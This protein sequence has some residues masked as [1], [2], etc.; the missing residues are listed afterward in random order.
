MLPRRTGLSRWHVWDRSLRLTFGLTCA[1]C[2]R[3]LQLREATALR[4]HLLR[5]RAALQYVT[6]AELS[7]FENMPRQRQRMRS[8]R[9]TE[10]WRQTRRRPMVARRSDGRG[11]VGGLGAGV[12]TG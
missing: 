5:P 10:T 11:G 1:R 7:L 9:I 6:A 8:I 3:R 12:G 4:H 2:H